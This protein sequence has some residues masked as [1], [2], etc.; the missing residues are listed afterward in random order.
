MKQGK[1]SEAIEFAEGCGGLN[2]GLSV[3]S[4]CEQLLLEAGR[5]EEAYER[6]AHVVNG[7]NS[8]LATYRRIPRSIRQLGLREY[9]MI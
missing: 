7:E 2:D 6:Y 5:Y 4:T 8:Y 3:A 9:W 1:I